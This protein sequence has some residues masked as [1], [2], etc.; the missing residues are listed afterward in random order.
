MA[1]ES[2]LPKDN[3]SLYLSEVNNPLV[4]IHRNII[5][6]EHINEKTPVANG[7]MPAFPFRESNMRSGR[8]FNRQQYL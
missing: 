5:L 4:L 2:N 3:K 6:N 8:K 7:D 1:R